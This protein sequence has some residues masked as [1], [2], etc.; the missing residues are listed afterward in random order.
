M[1]RHKPEFHHRASLL[2]P[3]FN[4]RGKNK[5]LEENRDFLNNGAGSTAVR[6]EETAGQSCKF[7]RLR[8]CGWIKTHIDGVAMVRVATPTASAHS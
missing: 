5:S 4:S 1:Q 6:T 8:Q 2:L 3:R 7:G